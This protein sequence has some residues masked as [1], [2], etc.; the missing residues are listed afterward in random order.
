MQ[1]IFTSKIFDYL[2]QRLSPYFTFKNFLV[3]LIINLL[4]YSSLLVA[5]VYFADDN[6][7]RFMGKITLGGLGRVF[8]E[9]VI[10]LWN[11]S[12]SILDSSPLFQL[13]SLIVLSLTSLTLLAIFELK[14]G[15]KQL[16]AASFVG[17]FPLYY[18]NMVYKVDAPFMAM[19]IFFGIVPFL[20]FERKKMFILFSLLSSLL[21]LSTYQTAL[22][23]Y[24]I[25]LAMFL[26][27][28]WSEQKSIEIKTVLIAVGA[29][30]LG[31][32]GY[33]LL[34]IPFVN[35]AHV[36]AQLSLSELIPGVFRNIILTF[37]QIIDLMGMANVG[38]IMLLVILFLAGFTLESR[39]KKS[40]SLL[41]VL[42]VVVL[43]FVFT[44]SINLLFANPPKNSRYLLL[45]TLVVSLLAILASKRKSG[46]V[47]ICYVI[48]LMFFLNFDNGVGNALKTQNERK[49]LITSQLLYDFE[50]LVSKDSSL[51]D[52]K[53]FVDPN[54]AVNA[55]AFNLYR[56]PLGLRKQ[57]VGLVENLL[58]D[59]NYGYSNYIRLFIDQNMAMEDGTLNTDPAGFALLLSKRY[60]DILSNGKGAYQLRL[61]YLN[62]AF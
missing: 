20:F 10:S 55:E 23:G 26:A 28:R 52:V 37:K 60:Y 14:T 36:G 34:M 17:I 15:Y 32:I 6:I 11:F 31:V 49:S 53:I 16:I 62:H 35:V 21:V 57:H 4:A 42:I 2:K 3:L 48:I 8:D 1:Q 9:A 41:I 39:Q 56:N 18:A 29:F 40:F 38:I 19:S 12:R 25:M 54:T 51:V 33:R 45:V 44:G 59:L 27:D 24:F 13:Y 46:F 5:D 47:G 30:V 7:R 58:N 43:A 22:S 50:S 61:R